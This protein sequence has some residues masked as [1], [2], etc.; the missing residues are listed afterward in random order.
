MRLCTK[1][2]GKRSGSVR[3]PVNGVA[4]LS[5]AA[6]VDIVKDIPHFEDDQ[7]RVLAAATFGQLHVIDIYVPNGQEVC[8]EKYQ[9]KLRRLEG[10]GSIC[11]LRVRRSPH[12]APRA[13]SIASRGAGNGLRINAPVVA[14]FDMPLMSG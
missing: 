4:L 7:R 8:S 14:H 9:Y 5:R 3:S 11:T 10:C 2:A 1:R 13:G 12:F 6:A